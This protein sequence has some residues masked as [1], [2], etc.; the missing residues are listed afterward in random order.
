M[1][2]VVCSTSFIPLG[3]AQLEALG[4]ADTPIAVVP[5]PF[6]LHTREEVRAIAERCVDDIARLALGG[7]DE[8]RRSDR[9]AAYGGRAQ[10]IEV[11]DE[12]DAF[13]ELCIERRWSDGLPLVAPTPARVERA[14]RMT[15]RAPHEVVAHIAPGFGQASIETIAINAVM[16]G[17]KPEF[18]PVVIAAVEAVAQRRFNLQGIQAT[19]NSAAPWI[20]VNGPLARL[21]G[22]NGGMN[23]EVRH[24]RERRGPGGV[25]FWIPA[26]AGMTNYDEFTIHHTGGEPG[27]AV[28]AAWEWPR[29]TTY[30]LVSCRAI[31]ST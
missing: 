26:C 6:G 30:R 29:T 20:I 11:S 5:H 22:F 7:K 10:Q 12:F 24:P 28:L 21:L 4:G 19:T 27:H 15:H 13:Q 18:L 14:L 23:S 17:C 1:A 3:R 16:A 2:M 9:P 8:T 25:S 31:S